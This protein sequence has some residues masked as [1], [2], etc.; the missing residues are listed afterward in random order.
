MGYLHVIFILILG[1]LVSTVMT[2]LAIPILQ[3]LKTGQ[4]IREEGPSSHLKKAGTPT[5]GGIAII[6][7]VAFA[8]ITAR[9][10][11]VDLIVILLAFVLF[12]LLGFLDDYL[13]VVKKHNLGLRAWQKLSG[14][15]VLAALLAFY[16][17]FLTSTG[18]SVIIPF[19]GDS[20]DFGLLGV[21]FIIFDVVAMANG[22]HLTDGLYGLATTLT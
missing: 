8:A 14:Q 5:M 6:A 22:V 3:R 12:G 21:P 15:L 11:T 4:N 7:G 2:S 13:K 18:A 20:V 19:I 9:D 1:M 17:V 10:Y 16:K